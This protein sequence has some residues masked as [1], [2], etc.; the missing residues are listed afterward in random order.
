MQKLSPSSPKKFT[1]PLLTDALKDAGYTVTPEMEKTLKSRITQINEAIDSLNG[2]DSFQQ[3]LT[4]LGPFMAA[5][6]NLNTYLVEQ[7]IDPTVLKK[8]QG[9]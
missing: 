7:G 4:A 3:G 2:V 8:S 5:A 9:R 6:Q 1:L